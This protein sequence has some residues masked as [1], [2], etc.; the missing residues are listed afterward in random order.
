LLDGGVRATINSDDPA[1]F[2]GYMNENFVAVQGAVQ[3]SKDE[4]VQLS[5]NA[6]NITWLPQEDRKSYVDALDDYAAK[7]V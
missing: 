2:N 3:L 7:G 5:R 4:I 1:Y 6:F